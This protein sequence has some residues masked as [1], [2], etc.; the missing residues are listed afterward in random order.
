MKKWNF[1]IIIFF[2]F[3]SKITFAENDWKVKDVVKT[4]VTASFLQEKIPEVLTTPI[5]LVQ[6]ETAPLM[7]KNKSIILII[8]KVLFILEACYTFAKAYIEGNYQN[9]VSSFI[10]RAF[11]GAMFYTFI[12]GGFYFSIPV[13]VVKNMFGSSSAINLNDPLATAKAMLTEICSP[14]AKFGIAYFDAAYPALVST[15]GIMNAINFL[16]QMFLMILATIIIWLGWF[17][18]AQICFTYVMKLMEITIGLAVVIFFIGLKGSKATDSYF[19]TALKYIVTCAI[20]LAI[21]SLVSN[22]GDSLLNG[23]P[24]TAGFGSL[25]S[26]LFGLII[27][28]TLYKVATKIGAG[29]ASGSPK[30]TY[31]DASAVL[32]S[33]TQIGAALAGPAALMGA[34]GAMAGGAALGAVTGAMG[35]GG[36]KGALAGAGAGAQKGLSMGKSASAAVG[37]ATGKSLGGSTLASMSGQY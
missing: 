25:I 23:T 10:T 35:G 27:W 11:F 5:S 34:A 36:L 29:I 28:M 12:S 9:V 32:Q 20:D 14:W 13:E 22:I 30:V 24:A 15:M 37:K 6:K 8:F 7:E 21:L 2:L 1:I 31:A 16:G 4:T 17:I 3:F 26:A 33:V 18:V 19:E